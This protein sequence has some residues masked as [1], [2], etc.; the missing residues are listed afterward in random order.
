MSWTEMPGITETYAV[1]L[2]A[3]SYLEK[4]EDRGVDVVWVNTPG[5]RFATILPYD[6]VAGL[7]GF[8]T[9]VVEDEE[10]GVAKETTDA[11]PPG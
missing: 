6:T 11:T 10:E 3:V 8:M 1:N 4:G 2:D 7:L 5:H 9:T